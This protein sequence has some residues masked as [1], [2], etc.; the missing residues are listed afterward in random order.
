[1]RGFL[2]FLI[3]SL[4]IVS[5]LSSKRWA[6]ISIRHRERVLL[7]LLL[8]VIVNIKNLKHTLCSFPCDVYNYLYVWVCAKSLQ[9]CPT[10]CDPMDCSPPGPSVHGT[11]QARILEWVAILQ[12]GLPEPGIK[13]K[14]L[15]SLA[16]AGG[17]FTTSDT[18]EASNYL[19]THFKIKITSWLSQKWTSVQSDIISI[20]TKTTMIFIM[21]HREAQP[22]GRVGTETI[23]LE[24]KSTAL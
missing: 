11:L 14:S 2:C 8:S 24:T 18:W 22:T 1:M 20:H 23:T 5:H 21:K 19:H 7:T 10:L 9:L 6:C 3:S 17:F 13:H 15:M 4:L 12:G 16:L